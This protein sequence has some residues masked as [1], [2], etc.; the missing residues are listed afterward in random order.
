MTK[1]KNVRTSAIPE[2]LGEFLP[3]SVLGIFGRME[4]AEAIIADG[5]AEWPEHAEAIDRLFEFSCPSPPLSGASEKLY[6]AHVT[7]LVLRVVNGD[8]LRPGTDAE[9]C[10]VLSANSLHH[11]PS[12]DWAAAYGLVFGRVFPEHKNLADGLVESYKGAAEEVVAELRAKAGRL[13]NRPK[14]V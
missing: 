5:K 11:P 10:A 1:K 13:A 2:A 12:Q 9:V 4:I 6:R 3:S 14:A 8:D 7:E